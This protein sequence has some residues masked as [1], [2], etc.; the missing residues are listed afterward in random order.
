MR[1]VEGLAAELADE[2][3]GRLAA[4]DDALVARFPGERPG[5]QPVHTGYVPADRYD[6]DLASTW[7]E[8]ARQAMS[9]HA[10]I[11]RECLGESADDLIPLVDDKLRGEPIEDLRIDFE[12]GY[13]ARP[14]DVEDA[15]VARAA[16][17]LAASQAAGPR[18]SSYGIRFKSFERPTRRRGLAT[19]T[20]F[21]DRLLAAGGDL[22]G[23]VVT[24]PKVTSVAQVE[25]MAMTC[26]RIEKAHGLTPGTLRFEIQIE[27]PQSILGPDGTAL[28]ARMVHAAP[29]RVTGLHYGTYDY[30]A[31][32]GIAAAYQS[33]EHP[34][35]DHAKAVMQAAAAGT[36]IRL[37]DGSTNILPVGDDEQVRR[38]WEL[39]LRL[40]RRSLERGFYQG[41]DLHPAQLPTRYT[42][43]YAFYRDG[44]ASAVQRLHRYTSRAEGGILDE[45]ATAR[46]LAD[47]L[48][49]G[50]ECGAL[51]DDETDATGMDRAALTALARPVR[52]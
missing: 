25:A 43:T 37:S 26:E 14:D 34:V 4:E 51:H 35:A 13:G 8:R 12:D 27:T 48:V 16:T 47:F 3:D 5:R 19:L 42:A 40:V 46:A 10:E 39:H 18:P 52:S 11:L 1:C 24:L 49:R 6:A 9:D 41:W 45:P 20:G 17:A 15:D 38:G 33:M 30:S 36:G 50:L 44:L 23:F 7:G 21:V 29:R 32:C 2:L 28:V 22:D 31:F